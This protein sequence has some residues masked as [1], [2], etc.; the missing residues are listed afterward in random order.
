MKRI[1]G[2]A[3]ISILALA[4]CT[5]VAPEVS[6]PDELY[7]YVVGAGLDCVNPEFSDSFYPSLSCQDVAG[8]SYR[9][10][11]FGK[12]AGALESFRDRVQSSGPENWWE[13]VQYRYFT[14][15]ELDMEIAVGSNWIALSSSP[16][17][18]I[19]MIADKLG[20]K[21]MNNRDFWFSN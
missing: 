8:G 6:D 14:D 20:A 13:E 19:Q 10:Y 1:Q 12:S 15:L 18:T 21:Q 16:Q 3:A 11:I 7:R 2:L 17:Y 5:P 4:G 9:F